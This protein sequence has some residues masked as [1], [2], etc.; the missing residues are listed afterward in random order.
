MSYC[1]WSSD[2]FECDVYVY[3]N[4]SGAWTTHVAGRRFKHIVPDELKNAYP[5][6]S[7]P[8]WVEKYMQC[9]AAVEAWRQTFPYDEHTVNYLQQDGT[10]KPGVWRSPKDSEFFDLAEIGPEAGQSYDDSCPG[11]CADRLEQLKAR[12]FNVPQYA[13]DSLREEQAEIHD[14]EQTPEV[15]PTQQ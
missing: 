13:I 1:R 14:E 5:K 3:A 15:A 12:G 2:F 9:E 10:T 4:V 11:E 6:Q 8:Q 7:D